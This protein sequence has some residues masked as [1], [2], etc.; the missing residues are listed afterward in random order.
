MNV[1]LKKGA[2]ASLYLSDWYG[3]C[4]VIKQRLP[5]AYRPPQLDQTI[6]RYRTV[7]EP[8]LMHEA[9]RAGVPTPAIFMVDVDN[10]IIVMEYIEGH[11]VKLLLD[12]FNKE[13][14]A[15][16][17]CKIGG[18][19]AKLHIHGIV[20]GDLTTSNLILSREGTLFFVDFGLGDKTEEMEPQGVDLHL[21]KRALQSTHFEHA[22]ECFM[23]VLKGYAS[24]VGKTKFA[25]VCEKIGEIEKRGRYVAERQTDK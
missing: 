24:I 10:A 23:A 7:H 2:E 18:E 1:L 15:E 11:Q 5:K 25:S 14:R 6:R 17:C 20:H 13:D 12:G 9:K 21:L 22:D 3:K 19:I 16:L 4:V 8:Q